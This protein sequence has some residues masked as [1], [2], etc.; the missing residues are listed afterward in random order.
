MKTKPGLMNGTTHFPFLSP[1]VTTT[2]QQVANLFSARKNERQKFMKI[3]L[4]FLSWLPRSPGILACSAVIAYL[5][6]CV[7]STFDMWLY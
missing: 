5:R 6:T 4:F 3:L 1:A 2:T 7:P